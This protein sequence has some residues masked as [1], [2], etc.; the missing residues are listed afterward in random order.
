MGELTELT[1]ASAR[2]LLANGELSSR[3]L[4]QDHVSA[5]SKAGVL[6]AIITETPEVAL[7]MA[8]ASDARRAKGSVGA[9]EGIPLAIKDIFCTQGVLTT[10]GSHILDNFR[11]PYES[12]V[13]ANLWNA[14]AVM[15]GKTNMDEFAMGSSNE[16]SYYGAV[17][18]PWRRRD[19]DQAP[20]TGRFFWRI[21]SS[22]SWTFC[23]GRD[24]DG[25]LPPQFFSVVIELR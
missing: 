8:D 24:G 11:P 3:E 16:T 15:L 1:I 12:T 19:D 7:A 22:R 2:N 25:I 10:P 14:G 23:D 17:Q 20:S 5:V 21:C 13:S 6:N 4:T 18:N 9:L